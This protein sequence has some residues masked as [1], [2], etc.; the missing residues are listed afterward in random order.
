[1]KLEFLLII[2]LTALFLFTFLLGK[3]LNKK[4]QQEIWHRI[5]TSLREK[6]E[7]NGKLGFKR[8]DPSAYIVGIPGRKRDPF[9]RLEISAS[10]LPRSI[11]L[12]YL[13]SKLRGKKDKIIIKAEF[14]GTPS[15]TFEIQREKKTSKN[16]EDK[17]DLTRIKKTRISGTSTD[18]LVAS[19]ETGKSLLE[20]PK[21]KEGITKMEDCLRRISISSSLPHLIL[22]FTITEESITQ[23]ISLAIFLAG[24][25]KK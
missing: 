15:Y 5:R 25:F 17:L 16:I 10:L 8:L 14:K 24:K 1:M 22:S 9:K 21:L 19:T 3:K 12:K 13:F 4:R 20:A 6:W 7:Y 23:A 18:F 2:G 11:L